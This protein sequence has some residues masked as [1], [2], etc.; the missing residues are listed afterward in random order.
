MITSVM[1]LTVQSYGNL[2]RLSALEEQSVIM[3]YD[4]DWHKIIVFLIAGVYGTVCE[5]L[6]VYTSGEDAN[7]F[8]QETDVRGTPDSWFCFWICV[9]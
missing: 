9:C 3:L 4:F 7:L 2:C 8:G 1:F 5:V 6:N